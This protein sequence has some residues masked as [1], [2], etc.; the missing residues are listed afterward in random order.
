[1]EYDDLLVDSKVVVLI[2]LWKS[3]MDDEGSDNELIKLD[4]SVIDSLYENLKGLVVTP[5]IFLYSLN[6][7]A[8]VAT[9]RIG[10]IKSRD[11]RLTKITN[12][13]I[14]KSEI[15]V[16]KNSKVIGTQVIPAF[17]IVYIDYENILHWNIYKFME[18]VKSDFKLK[19]KTGLTKKEEKEVC[20]QLVDFESKI[21]NDKLT[22]ND[23]DTIKSKITFT[24][25]ENCN[26]EI[27]EIVNQGDG[28]LMNINLDS[29]KLTYYYNRCD[30]KPKNIKVIVFNDYKSFLF[31]ELLLFAS[32]KVKRCLNCGRVLPRRV[33]GKMYKGKYCN[34]LVNEKCYAERERRRQEKHRDNIV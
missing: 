21:I 14:N 23:L 32:K 6:P 19:H 20:S 24:T 31:A 28:T 3:E 22:N 27:W 33:S 16:Y 8:M 18:Y 29:S 10:N 34:E 25:S 9:Y 2:P 4:N 15:E 5:E 26:S 7:L 1:M 30:K 17:N 12:D 13:E 11:C